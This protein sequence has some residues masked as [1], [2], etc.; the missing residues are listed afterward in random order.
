LWLLTKVSKLTWALLSGLR[1]SGDRVW[2]DEADWLADED[3]VYAKAMRLYAADDHLDLPAS[4]AT[5][6][7]KLCEEAVN[8]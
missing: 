8:Y 2:E 1:R 3:A 6:I 5:Y 7:E 4:L